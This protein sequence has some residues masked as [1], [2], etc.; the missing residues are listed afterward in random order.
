MYK[1]IDKNLFTNINSLNTR[2]NTE[3]RKSIKENTTTDHNNNNK[4]IHNAEKSPRKTNKAEKSP[5]QAQQY[6]Y[7]Y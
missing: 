3:Q 4:K 2:T 7:I 5:K 6:I 1:T